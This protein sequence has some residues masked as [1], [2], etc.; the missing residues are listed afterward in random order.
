MW[1]IGFVCLFVGHL[2][3]EMVVPLG[4]RTADYLFLEYLVVLKKDCL[5]VLKRTGYCS[6]TY[7][8]PSYQATALSLLK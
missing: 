4:T 8:L 7:I 6:R 3:L 5:L 1:R 2:C